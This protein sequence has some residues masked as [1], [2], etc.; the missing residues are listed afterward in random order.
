[1]TEEALR[2]SVTIGNLWGQAGSVINMAPIYLERGEIDKC[3][4]AVEDALP[5]AQE[6]GFA[7]LPLFV[8]SIMAWVYGS[9]GGIDHGFEL[10]RAAL[11]QSDEMKVNEAIGARPVALA[12][13]AHLHLLKGDW[14]EAQ[15]RIKEAYGEL[16]STEAALDSGRMGLSLIFNV[17]IRG[18]VALANKEYDGV[19]RLA[20]RTI[21]SMRERGI[22]IFVSDTL[23][24]K[25]LA[26]L[27]LGL[28]SEAQEALAEARAEAEALGSRRSLWPIMSILSQL[29]D[30]H[31][32]HAE[33]E[34]LRQQARETIE[35]IADHTGTAELRASFLNVPQ[36]REVLA[37]G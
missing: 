34:T 20:N 31:G 11:A 37:P 33:A 15:A 14:A 7:A 35:Y 17:L 26:L 22:R 21:T 6:G 27:G 19:V 8:N 2:I 29:E 32:N 4:Q 30:Q 23:R 16:G 9:L 10:A 28:T 5:L 12:A 24:L 36:V 13:L 1:M 18:E 3:I 25:G